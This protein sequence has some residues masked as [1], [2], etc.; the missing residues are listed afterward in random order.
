MSKFDEDAF[1]PF[2]QVTDKDIEQDWIQY[3]PLG[4][5]DSA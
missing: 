4:N 5:T 2:I 3:Q 1:Y